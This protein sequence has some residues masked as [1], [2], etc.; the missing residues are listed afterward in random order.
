VGNW[1]VY[2]TPLGK[3]T[4]NKEIVNA[5]L[6][7]GEPFQF[8]KE[9]HIRE[10][11]VETQIAFLQRV[12]RNFDIVPIVMGIPSLKDCEKISKALSRTVGKKMSFLWH[13]LT[14]PIILTIPTHPRLIKGHFP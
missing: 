7:I 10:H 6:G 8:V 11:S 4:V 2:A 9:A 13:H 12:L 3:V 1:D 14:C 5:L